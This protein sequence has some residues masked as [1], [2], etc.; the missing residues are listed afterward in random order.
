MII[1]FAIAFCAALILL[2]GFAY[3]AERH[4]ERRTCASLGLSDSQAGWHY[5]TRT[6]W[7]VA[8]ARKFARRESAR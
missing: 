4:A 8:A 5:C 7:S 1:R 6:C 3:G 2:V